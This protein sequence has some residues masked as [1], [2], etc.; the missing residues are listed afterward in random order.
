MGAN[1]GSSIVTVTT[2]DG[3]HTATSTITV[4]A[5]SSGGE[6]I[7]LP[8]NY[9]ELKTNFE[10]A[11]SPFTESME[12]NPTTQTF[13]ADIN[14][15]S[16]TLLQNILS[17]GNDIAQWNQGGFNIHI[18]NKTATELEINAVIGSPIK[19]SG[20]ISSNGRVKIAWSVDRFYVNGVSIGQTWSTLSSTNLAKLNSPCQYGAAQGTTMSISHYNTIGIINSEKTEEEL[21]QL[22]AI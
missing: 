14:I 5:Q 1:E 11:G 17:I 18:Y 22:T 15:D 2:A 19:Y 10:P 7:I 6:E 13:Y 16:S 3:G 8:D 9:T 21:A 20:T 4:Q 12:F